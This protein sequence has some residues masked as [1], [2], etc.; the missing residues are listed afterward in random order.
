MDAL[1]IAGPTA[2]GKTALALDIAQRHDAEIINMD[3]AIVY[4]GMDI[5]TAKPS[6][7][8]QQAVI[9][10]LVDIRRP[11]Q[12]Y[13]AADFTRDAEA[14]V[15]DIR[16]RG[17]LPIVVGGTML[18][19]HSWLNGLSELPS[20][21]ESLRRQLQQAWEADPAALHQQLLMQDPIAGQ[22]I[23]ANDPQRIIRALE[24][25]QLTGQP[26]SALQHQRKPTQHA[27]GVVFVMPPS[28]EWLHA[29]IA[30]RFEQMLQAG[31]LTEVKALLDQ[32][33][34][35]DSPALRSVGYRQAIQYLA[36]EINYDE[37]VVLG[38]QATRQLAKRQLTWIKKMAAGLTVDATL[39]TMEQRLMTENFA[40]LR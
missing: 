27:L 13:S 26:L 31:L 3:S 35:P 36:G 37:M 16:A 22:R 4:Q 10:H 8:E 38:S 7:E 9:H 33:F 40:Q 2:V 5:G 14:L 39:G 21:D 32:G 24:V 17:K 15:T 11:D 19:L 23:H 6:I 12:A 18:Y 1:V 29:R 20:A 34:D 30:I 28:K 25:I